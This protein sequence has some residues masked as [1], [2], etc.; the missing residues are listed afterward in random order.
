MGIKLTL[1]LRPSTQGDEGTSIPRVG[2]LTCFQ[3]VTQTLKFEGSCDPL[4]GHISHAKNG[5]DVVQRCRSKM[6]GE[7]M[8]WC[9]PSI[10]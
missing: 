8:A 10:V 9:K 1:M 6:T 5:G 3:A 4:G 7:S 2:W